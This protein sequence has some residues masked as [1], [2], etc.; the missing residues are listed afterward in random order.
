MNSLQESNS[1]KRDGI[2]QQ[3]RIENAKSKI[4]NSK[5]E[6]TI[7]ELKDSN[8]R[9][10]N[11]FQYSPHP[12]FVL[13]SNGNVLK[14]NKEAEHLF[15]PGNNTVDRFKF[16]QALK[17]FDQ[18]TLNRHLQQASQT[19]QSISTVCKW[20]HSQKEKILKLSTRYFSEQNIFIVAAEDISRHEATKLALK[21]AKKSAENAS[22]LKSQFLA[23]MSHEIRNPLSS[24][25]GYIQ[26]LKENIFCTME[27]ELASQYFK[28][29][30]VNANHLMS[31]INNILDLSEIEAGQLHIDYSNED[32]RN[33]IEEVVSAFVQK[34]HEKGLI[35]NLQ[36]ADNVPSLVSIDISKMRQVLIN[37]IAN[38]I[39]FTDIGDV[40]ILVDWKEPTEENTA[41]ELKVRV[42]D[43]GIGISEEAR[44]R[45]FKNFSQIKSG[46][47]KCKSGTGLGLVISKKIA[48]L[49][50]G[51]VFLESSETGK[52]SCFCATFKVFPSSE[53]ANAWTTSIRE[54]SFA[55]NFDGRKTE[56][57][58]GI[59]ILSCEDQP[60]MQRILKVILQS[61]GAEVDFA[62]DGLVAITKA[63]Y[64]NYNIIFI[65]ME[66]P[67]C[68]G[69]KAVP[70]LRKNVG[71]KTPLIALTA[72]ALQEEKQKCL[73]LGC[74]GFISKPF[75]PKVLLETV[76]T[77]AEP[78]L[79][80]N[81]TV[82]E[83]TIPS[84]Y[85][86]SLIKGFYEELPKYLGQLKKS[87]AENNKAEFK[88]QCEIL[89][90]MSHWIGALQLE[91]LFDQ[92]SHSIGIQNREETSKVWLAI[93]EILRDR[94]HHAKTDS[95]FH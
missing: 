76:K 84:S 29:V 60:D 59:R 68:S 77:Y 92:L 41:G 18:N 48:N 74:Q 88:T 5:L 23:S 91:S 35:L 46:Q 83:P 22:R 94:Q 32:I 55:D 25:L 85:Q 11:F 45:L 43:S 34:A 14:Y 89:T 30:E 93:E 52:G 7:D 69:Y 47:Q 82:K 63:L 75:D 8:C 38:A 39:K 42:I 81:M 44:N 19:D 3:L 95:R 9:L 73:N 90:Q 66:M 86:K 72:N 79:N 54:N 53:P 80:E 61:V 64:G 50:D 57:L 62:D 15:I 10:H 70:F 78:Q 49:L 36:F 28:R 26:L 56:A 40:K 24:I 2:L 4:Q 17:F 87:K 20:K 71:I 65:D 31:I 67:G 1:I 6:N 16:K 21:N 58:H 37:L 27:D 33:E 12:Q 13:R 51:D